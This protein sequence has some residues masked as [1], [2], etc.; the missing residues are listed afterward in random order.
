M[1]D[2]RSGEFIDL[3]LESGITMNMFDLDFDVQVP[4]VQWWKS[5]P[6]TPRNRL[7]LFSV[8]R[9]AVGAPLTI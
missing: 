8:Q 9:A 1:G 7:R 6:Q 4:S 5:L 3:T 2:E